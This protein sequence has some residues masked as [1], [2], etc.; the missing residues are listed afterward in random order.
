MADFWR[1]FAAT[2]IANL[3]TVAFV[4]A[5]WNISWLERQGLAKGN[6]GLYLSLIIV[7]LGLAAGSLWMV[8]TG[9][10]TVAAAH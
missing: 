5:C 4:Y 6:R 9:S 7:V 3:F 2:L 1:T 10:V 8:S